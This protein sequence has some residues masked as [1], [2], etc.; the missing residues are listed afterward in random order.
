MGNTS[1]AWRNRID[2]AIISADSAAT[3]LPVSNLLN[4]RPGR[5]W[6]T[7]ATTAYFMAVFDAVYSIDVLALSGCTLDAADTVRHRLYDAGGSVLY[8]STAEACGVLEGNALH[9][10]ALAQAYSAKSWRC[11][12]VATSRATQG[13]FDIKRAFASQRW[14]P[15]IGMTRPWESGWSDDAD[16]VRSKRS[17]GVFVGD[18]GRYRTLN[19]Q[20]GWMEQ[21]E[22]ISYAQVMAY[23]AGVRGQV[24]CIPDETSPYIPAEA[25]FGRMERVQ[26]VRQTKD[27]VPPVYE[28][29]F[30]IQQDL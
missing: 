25:I 4:T 21:A 29:S 23:E 10:K 12:I 28:Q 13:Y 22:A 2:T 30:T 20:L 17:G 8:D 18:G 16:K 26:P 9:V 15:A 7:Q 19:V 5:V 24:L 1:F 3:T 27:T 14:K 11:D 6:R